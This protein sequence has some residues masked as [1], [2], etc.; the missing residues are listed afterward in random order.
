MPLLTRVN[1]TKEI[2]VGAFRFKTQ[3]ELKNHLDALLNVC[4]NVT[5]LKRFNNQYFQFLVELCRRHP[6]RTK[7]N[8][9]DIV[10]FRIAS[11]VLNRKGKTVTVVK[12]DLSECTVSLNTCV[13]GNRASVESLFKKSLRYSIC[14]QIIIFKQNA[15]TDKCDMCNVELNATDVHVDHV[16]HFEKIVSDFLVLHPEIQM[17]RIYANDI[18]TVHEQFHPVDAWIGVL[19]EAY[20]LQNAVLRVVCVNCNLTRPKW[21]G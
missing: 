13:T 18:R 5:S 16:V 21:R 8:L 17:P 2:I 14:N 15:K 20:H 3:K 9:V 11:N 6:D 19:F 4:G 7:K 10:D 12:K 1:S